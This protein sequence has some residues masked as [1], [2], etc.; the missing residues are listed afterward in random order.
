[1]L[2]NGEAF[3][4]ASQPKVQ[5]IQDL[6]EHFNIHPASVVI[7]RNGSIPPRQEWKEI[8]L[9]EKDHI[10]IIRFVSGG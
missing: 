7:D 4:L 1:M 9:E 3:P 6:L 2:V 8:F 10:E 5:S